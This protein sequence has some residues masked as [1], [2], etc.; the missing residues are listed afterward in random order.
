MLPAPIPTYI[1]YNIQKVRDNSYHCTFI[2]KSSKRARRHACRPLCDN[3]CAR[4]RECVR[5]CVCVCARVRGVVCRLSSS[6]KSG[7]I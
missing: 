3:L 1:E 7:D 6:F 5:V 2:G 4:V